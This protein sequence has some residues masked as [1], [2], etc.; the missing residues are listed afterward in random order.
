MAYIERIESVISELCNVF[1]CWTPQNL[2]MSIR[3]GRCLRPWFVYYG[4]MAEVCSIR[5]SKICGE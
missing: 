3:M 2:M 1:R 5:G 4:P